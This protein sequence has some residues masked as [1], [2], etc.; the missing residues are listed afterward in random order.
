VPPPEGGGGA[1]ARRVQEESAPMPAR[2]P[3]HEMTRDLAA[4]AAGRSPA[5]LVLRAGRWVNVCSGEILPDTDVAICGCRIAYC[6][7]Q[8]EGLIGPATQVID[9]EG[10]YL[11]PGLLDAHMHVESTLL[12]VRHFASAVLP[13]GTTCAFLDPHEIANVLGLPGVRLILDESRS[14]R[15]QVYVQIP[16]CVPAAPGLETSGARIGPEDVAEGMTWDGVIGLGEVMNYLGVAAGDEML[17]AE[18]AAAL[19]AG[20][21]VGGHYASPTLDRTFH[22]Y[23]ASG[24]SDC[25]EGTRAKDVIARVRQGM[26]AMIRES[27]A[28]R[29]LA[30]QL[31]AITERGLDPRHVL[32]CTDD[33][34]VGTLLRDGHMDDVVRRAIAAGVPAMT[35]IRMATLHTAEHF[36]VARDVGCIA[37]GRYAD[38]LLVEDLDRFEAACVIAAGEVVARRGRILIEPQPFAYPDAVRNSLHVGRALSSSDFVLP[39]STTRSAVPC[40]VIEVEEGQAATGKRID[41]I[42]VRRGVLSPAAEGDVA[43]LAVIE[44]HRASGRIGRGLVRGFRLAKPCAVASTVAHDSHNLIVLGTDAELMAAAANRVVELGGGIALF[45][46]ETEIAS[47]PLPIAGLMSESPMEEVAAQAERI[48]QGLRDCG[49]RIGDALMTLS[50]LALP[51]IPRLRLTDRGLIDVET[52]RV[53]PLFA[54]GHNR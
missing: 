25:H 51:V 4:V 1:A 16:A 18:I 40:H 37:P 49:C 30:A 15:M 28:W 38:I 27:S 35:A 11:V 36:G 2:T 43:F 7:P 34:H 21:R 12:N 17:H 45:R 26:A 20:G 13:H 19:R 8:A 32:L 6:G 47:L 54:D 42:P 22:A 33:R 39:V 52:F 50:L 48:H 23:A 10:T 41:E 46:G 3:L 5:D 31:P 14:T 9:A 24:P 44:R 29:D 53:V